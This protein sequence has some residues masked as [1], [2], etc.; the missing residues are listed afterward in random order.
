MTSRKDVLR[1]ISNKVRKLVKE[2]YK[3]SDQIMVCIKS[4]LILWRFPFPSLKA[5]RFNFRLLQ[6]LQYKTLKVNYL[7]YESVH[8][9]KGQLSRDSSR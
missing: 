4:I 7:F 6:K 2:T 8:N 9:Y 1:V 3:Y 5:H